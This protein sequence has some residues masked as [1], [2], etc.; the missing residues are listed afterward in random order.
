MKLKHLL[1]DVAFW[2]IIYCVLSTFLWILFLIKWQSHECPKPTLPEI[3]EKNQL[4][5]NKINN[6][7]DKPTI[8]SLLLELYGFKSR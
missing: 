4:I 7:N 8:D 1:K 2:I 5:I 3:T 6:A